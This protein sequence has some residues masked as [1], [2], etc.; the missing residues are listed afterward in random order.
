[1]LAAPPS[2]SNNSITTAGADDVI[3]IPYLGGSII[4]FLAGLFILFWLGGWFF[5]FTTV[6]SKVLSGAAAIFE[7]VWLAAWTMGG[8]MAI[9]FLYRLLRP[10]VPETLR[11]RANDVV[12][13]SGMPPVQLY[14]YQNQKEVW[15]SLF[16]GRK[17][18]ELSKDQLKTLR[19]RET[20]LG[21]RLTVDAGRVRLDLAR[22]ASEIE[23]EWLARILK[24]RY[25]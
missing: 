21:N 24:E 15:N 8:L 1:M 14:G 16:A 6:G 2:G 3:V 4:R 25:S 19:L 9:Y 23:R 18:V 11:L 20:D 7:V 13:D 5:E 17:I 10:S 12:Y 22:S